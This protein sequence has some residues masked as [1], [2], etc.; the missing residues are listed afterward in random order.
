MH[1]D[2]EPCVNG[3]Q[4]SVARR[5]SFESVAQR[6][7]AVIKYVAD[8]VWRTES[9]YTRSFECENRSPPYPRVG[10]MGKAG[11][12]VPAQGPSARGAHTRY[13]ASQSQRTG[14]LLR[15]NCSLYA[16]RYFTG[17]LFGLRGGYS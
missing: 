16:L 2:L 13:T 8:A 6:A 9:V 3:R 14:A 11:G 17:T 7:V 5:G 10:C 1:P 15:V 12:G 4:L